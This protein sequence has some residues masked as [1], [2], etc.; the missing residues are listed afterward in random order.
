MSPNLERVCALTGA[1]DAK[2]VKKVQ[3]LWSGYGQ[4]ARVALSGV[5]PAT[6]IIKEVSPPRRPGHPRGWATDRGHERKLRSY[7]VE[8]AF[9]QNFSGQ[10][11]A[12]VPALLGAETTDDG[13]LFVL[14]DLDACGFSGRCSRPSEEQLQACLRWL[15]RFHTDFMGTSP[16]GLWEA[17]TYWHL[18][19]RP[20]E[21]AAMTDAP[22]KRAAAEIDRRLS[23]A[24]HQTL[25]HGDAKLANFCFGLNDVAAVDFQYVGGGCGI[26]DVAY[27]LGS[28]RDDQELHQH[29]ERYLGDYFAYLAAGPQVEAEWRGLYP[30]AVADFHRFLA[31]WAPGHWKMDTYSQSITERVLAAL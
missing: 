4:I 15:A 26:R 24:T 23:C 3:T 13:W 20:D 10:T 29:G 28:C 12:R 30:F 21:L 25:V 22:L 18:E 27:L 2:L 1:T 5:G 31:G 6:V 14:E 16:A 19:T 9:Y 11:Q 8:M 17:G 7:A